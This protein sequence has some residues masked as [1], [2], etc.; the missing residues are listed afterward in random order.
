MNDRC[1]M[2]VA[3]L[4]VAGSRLISTFSLPISLLFLPRQLFTKGC[5]LL[6]N[7]RISTDLADDRYASTFAIFHQRY[8]TNTFP[9]L[10]A[11]Q[12]LRFLGHNGEINTIQGNENWMQARERSLTSPV[13][14]ERLPDLVAGDPDERSDSGRLDNALELL[15]LSGRNVLHSMQMMIPP[16]WEQDKELSAE[17][18]AWCEYHACCMEPWDG[19]AALIFGDGHYV[20]ATLDR[21]GLR[22]MRYSLTSHGLL[23]VASEAGVLP[24]D[25]FDVVERGRLGPGEMIAVDL[26]HGVLLRNQMIKRNLPNSSPISSGW[27]PI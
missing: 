21:N 26:E 11:G 10:A 12:P 3:L 2:L 13:W 18:R 24:I 16:A 15:T 25:I 23:I 6:P 19:P 27:M 17:E 8:S 9:I 1:T 20:G 22:P 5:S 7:W 4:S 14:G